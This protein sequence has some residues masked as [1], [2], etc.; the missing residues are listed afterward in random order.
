MKWLLWI[1]AA[2]QTTGGDRVTFSVAAHGGNA[3]FDTGLGWH[4]ELTTA[5]LHLGAV[6][7]NRANPISGSQE[8]SCI[9]PGLYTAEEL[10]PLEVDVL[11][12]EPQ[13]FPAPAEG[14]DDEAKTGELWL[15]GGDINADADAT[16]IAEI[17]GTANDLP[18]T[19]TV[20][21]STANRG[22]PPSDPALPSQ[23]PI[24]KQ[25]IVTPIPIDLRP[26]EGGTLEIAVDPRAWFA[27][28]DFSTVTGAIPDS[29]A[30]PAGLNL[31]SGLRAAAAAFQL[32]FH[33]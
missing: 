24:C 8:T 9:L 17:A 5:R 26:H 28:V 11:S 32:S 10:A 14:T 13:Q 20:T 19:A 29:N 18:F 21:I 30:D 4:V 31:F 6:Y 33:D 15:T 2:C 23:H 22:I 3:A 27:N 16:P 25:R 1:L 12:A 7:L